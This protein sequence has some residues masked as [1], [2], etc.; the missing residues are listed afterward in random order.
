M[1]DALLC[2]GIDRDVAAA[3]ATPVVFAL[4]YWLSIRALLRVGRE[5]RRGG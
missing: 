1:T 2:L 3:L 4:C 5:A